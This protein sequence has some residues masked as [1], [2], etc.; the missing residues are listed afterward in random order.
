MT[1]FESSAPYVEGDTFDACGGHASTTATASYHY[2]VPPSCLL[3]QLGMTEGAP[4]PQV[5][6]MLDGFPIYG[7]RG[8]GGVRLQTCAV[9]GGTFGVD[10]C[11]DDC[12]GY[13]GDTGDGYMY[14]YYFLG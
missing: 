5:G 2:H 11:T 13:Y 14:R 1:D 8:P 4:S 10:V 9:T 6:W 3:R 12:A 7:P